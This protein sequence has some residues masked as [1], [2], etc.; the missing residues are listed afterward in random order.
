MT[1]ALISRDGI[2]LQADNRSQQRHQR[3]RMPSRSTC[4]ENIHSK[5]ISA[6]LRWDFDN[7]AVK[8]FDDQLHHLLAMFDHLQTRS[9]LGVSAQELGSFVSS[10]H[11]G[12]NH[13][14]SGLHFS[15]YQ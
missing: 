8:N 12:Y 15:R 4:D 3:T 9:L 13:G 11:D 6:L 7:A 2:V 5:P 10:V 1:T 14:G